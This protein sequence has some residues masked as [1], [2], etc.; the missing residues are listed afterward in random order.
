MKDT[1]T[2]ATIR[3]PYERAVSLW[4]MWGVHRW[5]GKPF[6]DWLRKLLNGHPDC[7][8]APPNDRFRFSVDGVR[9]THIA[10][11]MHWLNGPVDYLVRFENR[12]AGLAEVSERIGQKIDPA[13]KSVV[14]GGQGAEKPYTKYLT[15]EAR[16]MIRELYAADFAGLG[17][18]D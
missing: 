1:Y 5:K 18:G 9:Y 7:F 11:Q 12:K 17:Y 16:G 10:P 14:Q 4:G 15:D 3:D 2:F 6:A 13:V 8:T